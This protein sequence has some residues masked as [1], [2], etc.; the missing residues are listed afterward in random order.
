MAF[1]NKDESI[2]VGEWKLDE[3]I[4]SELEK[5]LSS[6]FQLY[7]AK[8]ERGTIAPA[9]LALQISAIDLFTRMITC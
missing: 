3:N 2:N 9:V 7:K 5:G 4:K 8:Y 1:S 6:S